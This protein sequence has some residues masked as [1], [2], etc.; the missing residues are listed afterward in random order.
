MISQV[1]IVNTE[2][3]SEDFHQLKKITYEYVKEDGTKEHLLDTREQKINTADIGYDAEKRIVYVPTFW[4]NSVV[5][6]RVK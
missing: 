1:K 5:A 2:I 4:K 6:Y 3:I